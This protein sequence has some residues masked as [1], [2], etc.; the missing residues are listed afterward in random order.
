MPGF[1][2][3]E[4]RALAGF[5]DIKISKENLSRLW[6]SQE[7]EILDFPSPLPDFP[8]HPLLSAANVSR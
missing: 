4:I 8:P 7:V 1:L 6:Q 5:S 3:Y 2:I